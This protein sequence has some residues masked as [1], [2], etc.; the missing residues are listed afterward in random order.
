MLSAALPAQLAASLEARFPGARV[1]HAELSTDD[2][3]REYD[4]VAEFGGQVVDTT[5]SADGTILETETRPLAVTRAPMP[6]AAPS[7]DDIE[8]LDLAAA[9]IGEDDDVELAALDLPADVAAALQ[10]LYPGAR[11]IEAEADA[12]NGAPEVGLRAELNGEA[13]DVAFTLDGQLIESQVELDPA[14]LPP[15]AVDWVRRNFPGA[16]I[17]DAQAV[18]TDGVVTYELTITPPGR[19]PVEASLRLGPAAPQSDDIDTV[20]RPVTTGV[21]RVA[22][23]GP[24]QPHEQHAATVAGEPVTRADEQQARID[25]SQ[26]AVEGATSTPSGEVAADME[27]DLAGSPETLAGPALRAFA[28]G[29]FNAGTTPGHALLAADI[30]PVDLALAESALKEVLR[31]LDTYAMPAVPLELTAGTA[32][33]AGAVVALLAAAHLILLDTRKSRGSP[34]LF[35]A[36]GSTPSWLPPPATPRRR[37][38]TE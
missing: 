35:S 33:R 21:A 1:I 3:E 12:D 8:V 27:P 34:M 32:A 31:Q 24:E 20:D 14:D 4:V 19:A 25:S 2:G 38:F 11:V 5:L 7:D 17:H 18:T 22:F 9:D 36:A 10:A 13:V 15:A 28:A 29:M 26:L 30:L 6:P 16:T 23:I 37:Q